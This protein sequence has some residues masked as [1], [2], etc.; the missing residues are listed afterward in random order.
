[1]S[2]FARRLLVLAVV[3]FAARVAYGLATKDASG[4][5]GDALWY[6][7]ELPRRWLA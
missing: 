6:H 7:L 5:R 4:F 1:M 2:P 3:G